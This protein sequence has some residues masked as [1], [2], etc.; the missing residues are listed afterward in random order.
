VRRPSFPR[1]T[2]RGCRFSN[3][4]PIRLLALQTDQQLIVYL[5]H[6]AADHGLGG[7]HKRGDRSRILQSRASHLGGIDNAGPGL[8]LR[9][10]R[11]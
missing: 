3:R 1:T 11:S 2:W 9:N 4:L 8:G 10:V 5:L 7:E 6:N